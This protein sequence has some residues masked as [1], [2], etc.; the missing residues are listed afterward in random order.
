[1]MFRTRDLIA[2]L[3][4]VALYSALYLLFFSPVLF[5]NH[6]LAPGDGIIYFAPNFAS[7]RVFWE[8]LIWGG[9]PSIADA[10]LMLW[11]PPAMLF[12]ALGTFGYQPFILLAYVMSSSFMFG[13]VFSL[14]QSRI[15]AALSGCTFGL[16]GFMIAHVGHASMIHSAAWLPLT[17]WSLRMLSRNVSQRWWFVV[18]VFSVTASAL[19]GHPQIFAY[20][21]CLSG[22]FAI[23]EGVFTRTNPARYFF[24]VVA[25]FVLGVGLASI[26]LWP[27]KELAGL[28]WRASLNFKEF[29]AYQ[30]PL[31]QL[32]I[33]LFPYLY[34]GSPGSFYKLSYFGAW[35]SSSDGWGAGELSGYAGL[36]TLVLAIVGVISGWRKRDVWFW[37]TAA[38][39][40][41][42]LT[43]GESTPFATVIYHLPVL[44]KFRVPAR[45]FLELTFS[46][47]VM[48][49]FGVAA[50]QRQEL[51]QRALRSLLICSAA[52]I[53]LSLI[54]LGLFAAKINEL[55]IQRLGQTI[56][57][58]PWHNP[59]IAVPIILFLFV[60]WALWFWSCAPRSA[61]RT[62]VLFAALIVD[63]GS[64]G[65]FYEWHYRSPYKAFL[66]EPISAEKYRT[67]VVASQQ[68]VLPIRGGTGRVNEVLPN[69]SKLW[70]VPSASG[71]GPFILS[72]VSRLLTMPPHGTV[73]ESWRNPA[74]QALNLMAVRYVIVPPD[75]TG[76]P[77][78]TDQQGI[79]WA[80]N[81][82]AVDLGPGCNA[83]NPSNYQL[84]LSQPMRATSVAIVGAL[85]C[86]VQI[87]NGDEVLRLTISDQSGA[88]ESYSLQAGRDFSEWAFDCSGVTPTM[89]HGRAQVFHSYQTQRGGVNCEAHDYV[90]H[91]QLNHAV[92][93]KQL[94]LNWT[95]ASG[96]FALKKITAID[97]KGSVPLAAAAGALTDTTRWRQVGQIDSTNSGYGPEVTAMDQGLGV[98]FENLHAL[99]RAWLVSQVEH[100]SAEDVFNA[101]RSSRLPDG[102]VF[103]ASRTAL[104]EKNLTLTSKTDS[105]GTA[106]VATLNASS[107]EVKT[108][109]A[110][111]AF[112]VTSDVLYPG[113]TATVDG[114]VVELYQ[115]D[116][117]LRGVAVPAGDHVVRF[118]FHPRSFYQGGVVSLIAALLLAA[119]TF[120]IELAL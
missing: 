22:A 23:V 48:A 12:S 97:E 118:E 17:I 20:A 95:G 9:Y 69:L 66:L 85:A 68:R 11:Y 115:T 107:M 80:A 88:S 79:N 84:S 13:F 58:T 19:A 14:T 3:K 74:N 59:A 105:T 53:L 101:V 18:A 49:G 40:A 61:L 93:I 102:R 33:L 100:L 46:L 15:A 91:I 64:F 31:R 47:S 109:S 7:T 52:G 4:V 111:E 28:S 54:S 26:Q 89:Q 25:V 78:L 60:C 73:D 76:P 44:N 96:T 50:L 63:L 65:W 75:Q 51:S 119:F 112:L 99:P 57:L 86:S 120:G 82:L 24:I 43:L 55:A 35:P 94:A 62:A 117:T 30:L 32:P 104:V 6:I 41:L 37:L 2:P 5:S 110:T 45:H 34:G 92:D 72:R 70:Q 10:Q 29:V 56:T 108:S 114:K 90:A 16:S 116:Y 38:A 81:D 27:T 83:K 67:D 8:Q 39:V 42:L 87:P 1:M 36:L 113:W 98:V 71:Y 77:Q 103:D 21:M 106:S